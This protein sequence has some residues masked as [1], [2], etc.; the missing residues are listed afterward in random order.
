[1]APRMRVHRGLEPN[2]YK[3]QSKGRTYYRYKHPLTGQL[4]SMGTNL[5]KANAAAR[6]LNAKL[7]PDDEDLAAKVLAHGDIPFAELVARYRTDVISQKKAA[8][9][10]LQAY[11]YRLNRLEQDLGSRPV[12]S[13]TV[14][15]C[16]DYLDANFSRNPYIKHRTT[17]VE[18][19]RY[20]IVKGI[21]ETN[22][23]EITYASTPDQKE[24]QRMTVE[25]YKILHQA[26]PEWLKIAMELALLTLLGRW[27]ITH[28]KFADIHDGALWIVREKSKEHE[29]AHLRIALTPELESIISRARRSGVASPYLVH[30]RPIRAKPNK[31]TDH[32]TQFAPNTFTAEFRKLRDSLD[33]F[34]SI[35]SEQRPT[36]HEIRALGSH[37]YEKAGFSR[38]YVQ[39]LMAHADPKMTEHYQTGHGKKWVEVEAGLSLKTIL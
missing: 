3:N 17:L 4:H 26:A 21:R 35:P 28:A 13:F 18:L 1:M 32:W 23:A 5:A 22:P 30:R 20:A 24:R 14:K 7:L 38:D 33:T 29:W 19:F 15:D 6:I 34:Q 27:E 31:D 25:Q 9:G 16:A 10:T 39:R 37:L 36:F 2:L 11:H 12:R 8:A